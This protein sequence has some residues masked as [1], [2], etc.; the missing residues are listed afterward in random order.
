MLGRC[1][2]AGEVVVTR[3]EDL[4]EAIRVASFEA[5]KAGSHSEWAK[6]IN[7]AVDTYDMAV[8]VPEF[9]FTVTSDPYSFLV[10]GTF[11]VHDF[12]GD[13]AFGGKRADRKWGAYVGGMRVWLVGFDSKEDAALAGWEYIM[14]T[15]A[16]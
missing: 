1:R 13:P 2:S 3:R 7:E 11:S 15:V 12:A 9:R 5:P 14:G 16:R 4:V 10:N 6:R 8:D